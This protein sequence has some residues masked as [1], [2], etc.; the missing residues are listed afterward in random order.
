MVEIA[1]QDT[2]DMRPIS[3]EETR[4]VTRLPKILIP[5]G[6]GFYI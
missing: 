4:Q 2:P 6:G 1:R 5:D 3:E